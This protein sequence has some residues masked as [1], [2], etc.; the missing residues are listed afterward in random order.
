MYK[1]LTYVYSCNKILIIN[2]LCVK[3][4]AAPIVILQ[5]AIMQLS[6]YTAINVSI[7]IIVFL[8]IGSVSYPLK[9]IVY[10]PVFV[11]L[12]NKR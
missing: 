2:I 1:V 5:K 9:M 8:S 4:K 3:S 7:V 6:V 11:L 12:S 10:K